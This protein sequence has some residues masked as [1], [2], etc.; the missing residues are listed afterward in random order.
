MITAVVIGVVVLCG[1][2]ILNAATSRKRTD[3]SYGSRR[4]IAH[5]RRNERAIND[6]DFLRQSRSRRK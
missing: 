4:S 1:G 2:F 3:Q 6:R 5:V